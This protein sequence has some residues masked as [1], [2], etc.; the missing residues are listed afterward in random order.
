MFEM[1]APRHPINNNQKYSQGTEIRKYILELRT[2]QGVSFHWNLSFPISLMVSSL[3]FNSVN[4]RI[5]KNL[6]MMAYIT[7]IQNSLIFNFMN[8]IILGKVTKLSSVGY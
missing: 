6:S 4:Y 3:N 1:L 2:L 5:L 8:M 7:E